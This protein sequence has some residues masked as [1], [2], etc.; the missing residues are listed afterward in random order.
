LF[1]V[2]GAWAQE[3]PPFPPTVSLP[4]EANV[5]EKF[6]E[7][8]TYQKTQD[9]AEVVRTLQSVL[10]APEDA[11]IA[12]RRP[13]KDGKEEAYWGS[14]RQEAQRMFAQLPPVAREF[15]ESAQGPRIAALVAQAR[16]QNQPA[17]LAE[18]VRLGLHTKAGIEAA[19]L[20]GLHH[21]D[22]GRPDAA[23]HCF[24]LILDENRATAWE[25]LHLFQ[26]ALAFHRSG[27][28]TRFERTW[29]LL[30]TRAADGVT[31]GRRKLSLVDLRKRLD[32]PNSR[33]EAEER[34]TALKPLWSVPLSQMRDGQ[35]WINEAL[36]QLE[37]EGKP[38][39]PASLPL[40]FSDQVVFRTYRGIAAVD[41]TDG[42]VLWESRSG[43]GLDMLATD[44]G[45][46]TH[47]NTWVQ[48]TLRHNPQM[49]LDNSVLGRLTAGSGHIYAIEDIPLPAWPENYPRFRGTGSTSPGLPF[50]AEL[51]DAIL[52]SRL[53]AI[54]SNSGKI[55][56]EIGGHGEGPLDDT[57]FLGPPLRVGGH[58]YLLAEKKQELKLLCLEADGKLLWSQTLALAKDRLA[59]D[60][61][62]RLH[63]APLVHAGGILVCPTNTGAVLCFDLLKRSIV[64]AHFYQKELPKVDNPPV[65]PGRKPG[66]RLVP[67][68]NEP[69]HLKSSWHMPMVMVA[70]ERVLIAAP[71][72]DAIL[73][74]GLR[75]GAILWRIEKAEGDLFV[76]TTS[77]LLLIAGKTHCRAVKLDEG[78]EAW[79]VETST[80]A[81]HGVRTGNVYHLPVKGNLVA[82]DLAKGAILGRT[83]IPGVEFPGNLVL[84][85]NLLLSQS[86]TA[87]TAFARS[88]PDK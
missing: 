19:R 80:P 1:I 42:S 21:L 67:L 16:K 11:F 85:G 33:P 9:W 53:L 4:T 68:V 26:A 48:N 58:L 35:V 54:E 60:G 41:R 43:V 25:P 47:M 6:R 61:G 83:A 88:V 38:V 51:S 74:V 32:S 8:R 28:Q 84:S 57:F 87:L 73:C 18:A 82:I 44:P 13:G 56:W 14:A 37:S 63:A 81:G 17:L 31:I 71:D 79:K 22:R 36:R 76:E 62:R 29:K 64:W 15:H 66:R 86:A 7:A 2:C 10:E 78:K 55:A 72:E 49:L 20:L 34:L 70:G 5:A 23:A 52:H 39:L 30:A 75:D 40:A 27:D 59:I 45:S 12:L 24:A 77:K 69:P 3:P 46:F 65:I 50:A